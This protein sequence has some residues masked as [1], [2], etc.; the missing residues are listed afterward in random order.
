MRRLA[1]AVATGLLLATGVMGCGGESPCE[2]ICSSSRDKLIANF[3]IK[4]E[5]IDCAD[6]KWDEASTCDKCAAIFATE[7]LVA[8]TMDCSKF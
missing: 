5:A 6:A 2:K 7:Y 1:C 4:P 3:G 8:A